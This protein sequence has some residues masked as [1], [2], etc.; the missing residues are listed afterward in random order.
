MVKLDYEIP[1]RKLSDCIT[2][3]FIQQWATTKGSKYNFSVSTIT[4]VSVQI[5]QNMESI[6]NMGTKTNQ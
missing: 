2:R 1:K 6:Q 5:F 4:E 3:Q